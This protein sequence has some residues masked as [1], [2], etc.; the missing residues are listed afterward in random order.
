[1]K[2]SLLDLVPMEQAAVLDRIQQCIDRVERIGVEPKI[3]AELERRD[4][5]VDRISADDG[6]IGVRPRLILRHPRN[7]RFDDDGDIGICNARCTLIEKMIEGKALVDSIA[8]VD[9]R[10]AEQLAQ[11]DQRGHGVAGFLPEREMTT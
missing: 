11:L 2:L 5:G 9:H 10:H 8:A 1:M 3:G 4:F 7:V 6:H